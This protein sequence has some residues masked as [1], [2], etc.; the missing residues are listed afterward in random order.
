MSKKDEKEGLSDLELHLMTN[1]TKPLEKYINQLFIVDPERS[2]IL[3]AHSIVER[4]LGEMIEVYL[5]EPATWL[6]EADFRS[7]TNLAKSIG[8]IAERETNIC[9]VLNSARNHVAHRLEPLP[10]KWR[11][12]IMRLNFRAGATAKG[13]DKQT[14]Q[15]AVSGLVTLIA[16]PWLYAR[17]K[18]AERQFH[19]QHKERGIQL[20]NELLKSHPDPTSVIGDKDELHRFMT[21]VHKTLLKEI[22]A[23]R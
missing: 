1:F 16:A 8:A 20:L 23:A 6:D 13:T 9:R 18:Q 21:E 11:L 12:E 2:L 5:K 17:T 7:R 4:M 10:D 22:G 3:T 15:V 19:E 14:L